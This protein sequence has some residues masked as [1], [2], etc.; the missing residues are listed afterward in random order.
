MY[1]GRTNYP[2]EYYRDQ[3]NEKKESKRILSSE[4]ITPQ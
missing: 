2:Q 3:S 4:I 1:E